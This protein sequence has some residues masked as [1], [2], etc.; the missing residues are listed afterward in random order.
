MIEM[1]RQR[2]R[3]VGLYTHRDNGKGVRL[4]VVELVVWV[5]WVVWNCGLP[6][7]NGPGLWSATCPLPWL[8]L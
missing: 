3:G 7:P 4:L 6:P 5:V 2:G 1:V 8:T